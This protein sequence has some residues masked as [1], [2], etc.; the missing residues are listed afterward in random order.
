MRPLAAP[1]CASPFAQ[2]V[3]ALTFGVLAV[4]S[5][6]MAADDPAA[7]ASP[8]VRSDWMIIPSEDVIYKYYPKF[9]ADQGV[10]GRVLLDCDITKDSK[11]DNCSVHE[12]K[13]EHYGFG[14]AA[15]QLAQNEIHLWSQAVA[16]AP[17][18]GQVNVSVAFNPKTSMTDS[19]I[20]AASTA[21]MP[22]TVSK[23]V[24]DWSET[25]KQLDWNYAAPAENQM[26]FWKAERRLGPDSVRGTVRYEYFSA[27][28]IEVQSV[29]SSAVTYD[30]DCK[31]DTF[32]TL[33]ITTYPETN[34][35][36]AGRTK[37]MGD[38]GP[39]KIVAGS[40]LDDAKTRVCDFDAVK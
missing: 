7:S 36:G 18:L 24:A 23:E 27:Q 26:T 15:I 20:L 17:L 22:S 12:E 8:Y 11:L 9:A 34:L 3:G 40:V 5:P 6:S 38:V 28:T 4:S 35:G 31:A 16:D 32:K 21:A 37:Q 14:E 25:V 30:F 2:F 29:R 1:A 39:L 10:I 13:P 33:A 19:A